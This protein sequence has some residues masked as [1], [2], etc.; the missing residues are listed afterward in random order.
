[1]LAAALPMYV[2]YRAAEH[3]T[4]SALS[5]FEANEHARDETR[6]NESFK[7]WKWKVGL[8]G[9]DDWT[10]F[11]AWK[12]QTL[13][14]PQF[15]L[16]KPE[17]SSPAECRLTDVVCR[18]LR[19]IPDYN[20]DVAGIHSMYRTADY[21]RETVDRLHRELLGT[22]FPER[23]FHLFVIGVFLALTGVG[24]WYL[25]VKAFSLRADDTVSLDSFS[26]PGP[27]DFARVIVYGVPAAEKRH[28]YHDALPATSRAWLD[29]RDAS[30]ETK[31]DLGAADVVALDEFDANLNDVEVVRSRTELLEQLLREQRK[32]K[33]RVIVLFVSTEPLNFVTATH[34]GEKDLALLTRFAAALAQFKLTYYEPTKD[35]ERKQLPAV[36]PKERWRTMRSALLDRL[37]NPM[38]GERDREIE[39]QARAKARRR[40]LV[41]DEC[42][43]PDLRA[44][45]HEM[46]KLVDAHQLSKAQIIQQIQNR[47]SAIYQYMWSRC[48]R[49]EK[50]TLM[51]L[52]RGNPINP[53]NWDAARRLQMRG[54]VRKAPFYRIASENLRQFVFRM[55][56]TENVESWRHENP[57]AWNQIKVPLVVMFAG[58]LIFLALTQPNLFNS[59]FAFLAAGAASFPFLVS[60]LSAR[61]QQAAKGGS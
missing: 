10:G 6:Q 23:A 19:D 58:T 59:M 18:V 45:G 11:S 3:G 34:H 39:R 9:V 8:T 13:L 25:L 16:P 48:T 21:D 31:G 37:K 22:P 12:N 5:R 47:A 30:S 53:N 36:S 61:L 38:H 43:H 27:K 1:M 17:A 26:V 49:V 4:L 28:R 51:E 50:F 60:A 33:L 52:A 29:L 35:V 41:A 46:S 40:K 57:G 32:G 42:R 14:R 54:Y 2:F 7:T 44:I 55:E 24:I 56:R 15:D 20:A